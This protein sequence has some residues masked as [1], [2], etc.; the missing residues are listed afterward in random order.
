MVS[1]NLLA[2]DG[3]GDGGVFNVALGEEVEDL[4]IFQEVSRCV[5]SVGDPDYGAPRPGDPGRVVLDASRA[6]EMLGWGPTVSLS[7]GVRRSVE[8]LR[9]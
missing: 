8:W 4:R 5:G 2:M 1:A 7:E 9:Q 3:R 6:R